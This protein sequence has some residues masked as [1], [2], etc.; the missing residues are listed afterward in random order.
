MEDGTR[1]DVLAGNLGIKRGT[2]RRGLE[3]L[4]MG[5]A[6]GS[7]VTGRPAGQ[8]DVTAQSRPK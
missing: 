4:P 1:A 2:R 5:M 3:P 8:G 7:T 6:C